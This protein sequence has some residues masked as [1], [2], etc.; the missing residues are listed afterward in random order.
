MGGQVRLKGKEMRLIR[1]FTWEEGF[2]LFDF[3]ERRIL[4]SRDVI[5]E[6]RVYPFIKEKEGRKDE[7]EADCPL[8]IVPIEES[9]ESDDIEDK[10]KEVQDSLNDGMKHKEDSASEREITGAKRIRKKPA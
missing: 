10:R 2:K 9:D 7:E 4:V 8:P 1:I 6:E 3:K 5:F